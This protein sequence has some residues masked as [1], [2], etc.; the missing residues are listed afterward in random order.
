MRVRI[1][2]VFILTAAASL[3]LAE[4]PA[5]KPR[6]LDDAK[7]TLAQV[8]AARNLTA[9]LVLKDDLLTVSYKT[10]KFMVPERL[11]IKVD[12]PKLHEEE[13]PE[14]DGIKMTIGM[15]APGAPHAAE[16]ILPH[17]LLGGLPPADPVGFPWRTAVFDD[18]GCITAEDLKT[19]GRQ[20]LHVSLAYGA[21]A[22]RGLIRTLLSSIGVSLP[23]LMSVNASPETIASWGNQKNYF[24][25][26]GFRITTWD[27][28][29][30]ILKQ[31]NYA[32]GH[33]YH[34]GWLTLLTKDGGKYLV[35]QPKVDLVFTFLKESKLPADGFGTE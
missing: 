1:L 25:H 19:P 11:K 16:N 17:D 6:N 4:E 29:K 13:G 22:D 7:A 21:E 2:L 8:F 26:G 15:E 31:N 28:A 24:L 12:N 30:L 18:C 27:E 23:Q 34:T 35:L 5:S 9:N 3:C 10:A 33:Q 14:P 32:G 20:F